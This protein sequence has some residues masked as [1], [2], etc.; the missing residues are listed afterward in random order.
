MKKVKEAKGAAGPDGWQSHEIKALSEPVVKVFY[1]ITE[2][3]EKAKCAPQNLAV[4]RHTN[5]VK[6]NKV[7]EVNGVRK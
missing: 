5:F 3:W 2:R 6:A 7:E 1:G 4:A